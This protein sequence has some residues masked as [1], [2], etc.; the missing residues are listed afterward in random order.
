MNNLTVTPKHVKLPKNDKYACVIEGLE[1]ISNPFKIVNIM[2]L[3]KITEIRSITSRQDRS[4]NRKLDLSSNPKFSS[5]EQQ[6]TSSGASN[7]QSKDESI[8]KSSLKHKQKISQQFKQSGHEDEIL[9]A[10]SEP[11]IK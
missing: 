6:P 3:P 11:E 4:K 5:K 1:N 10:E 2:D 9:L 7:K 8:I